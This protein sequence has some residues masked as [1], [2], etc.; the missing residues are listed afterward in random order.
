MSCN[1]LPGCSGQICLLSVS[2][3]LSNIAQPH[4][5]LWTPQV[6]SHPVCFICSFFCLS[7]SYLAHGILYV[8]VEISFFNLYVNRPS[9]CQW[10]LFASLHGVYYNPPHSSSLAWKI[11]WAEEPCGLQSMRSLRVGHDWATSVSLFTFLHWRRKWQ[12]TPVFFP[13]ESQGWGS[14]VG[15]CL[16][17][18]AELDTTEAA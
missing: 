9:L 6:L 12:P 1:P 17:G 13:G 4:W 15:C 11:P 14:L 2:A 3:V 7:C 16:W 10:R 5:G 8:S 18:R